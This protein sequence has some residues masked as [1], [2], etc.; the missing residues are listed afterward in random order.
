M[1]DARATGRILLSAQLLFLLPLAGF[2]RG[3]QAIVEFARAIVP[4]VACFRR[5]GSLCL[6]ASGQPVLL[7]PFRPTIVA[8]M[9]KP[10]SASGGAWAH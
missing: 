1:P 9:K 10:R 8:G 5:R 7:F 4:M 2:S 6:E 3:I